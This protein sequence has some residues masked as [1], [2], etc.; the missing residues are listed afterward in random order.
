MEKKHY[1]KITVSELIL[2]ANVSRTTFYRYYIDIFDMYE[3]ICT[4]FIEKFI[5]EALLDSLKSSVR[6]DLAFFENI[7][8]N[9]CSQ[10]RYIILLCGENGDR[11]FFER[12]LEI[13][14]KNL[15]FLNNTMGKEAV[16]R[17]KFVIC[18]GVGSYVEASLKN[19]KLPLDVLE[20]SKKIL[21]I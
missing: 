16:F 5:K 6:Y 17:L 11:R 15:K 21:G 18:A 4:E 9:I 20:I 2:K 14:E 13:A 12:V 19:E 1:S 8:N 10:N 3:K 7:Q